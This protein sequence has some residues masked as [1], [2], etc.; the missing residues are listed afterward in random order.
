MIAGF[1][2][3]ATVL[4]AI[5]A[6][7]GAA[8]GQYHGDID[9]TPST[10]QVES[11]DG[12]VRGALDAGGHRYELRGRE[13]GARVQ[14]QLQDPQTGAVLQFELQADE[15]QATLVV[16]TAGTE[17]ALRFT[18]NGAGTSTEASAVEPPRIQPDP[19]EVNPD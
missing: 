11:R 12:Q 19:G 15:V 7:A 6:S 5:G 10:L 8:G 16:S 2:R 13:D 14:G 17:I 18:R 1:S 4:L 9:G 3:F